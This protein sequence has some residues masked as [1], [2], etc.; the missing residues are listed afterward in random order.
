MGNSE[1]NTHSAFDHSTGQPPLTRNL[2]HGHPDSSRETSARKSQLV[3][4]GFVIKKER[5]YVLNNKRNRRLCTHWNSVVVYWEGWRESVLY[6][7]YCYGIMMPSIEEKARFWRECTCIATQLSLSKRDHY[8]Y[9][10]E[11]NELS[12]QYWWIS[13]KFCKPV[14]EP[15]TV[16]YKLTLQFVS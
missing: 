1:I 6:R 5:N 9:G 4:E 13:E 16:P 2:F 14:S 7:R 8:Y 15:K 10:R 12:L 11:K 3:T